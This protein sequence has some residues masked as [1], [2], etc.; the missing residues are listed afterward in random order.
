MDYTGISEEEL[1]D[2][3]DEKGYENL[4]DEEKDLY[5]QLEVIL[6]AEYGYD[7]YED[8]HEDNKQED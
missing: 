5:L 1:F 3:L 2:M 7:Y 4:T 8:E 6:E